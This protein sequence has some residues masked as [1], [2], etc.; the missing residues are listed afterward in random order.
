VRA[1]GIEAASGCLQRILLPATV[2]TA[3]P[4]LLGVCDLDYTFTL[5]RP[6]LLAPLP[7][8][9][10]STSAT[11]HTGNKRDAALQLLCELADQPTY[12]EFQMLLADGVNARCGP[13]VAAKTLRAAL[14]ML[15]KLE[16]QAV[17][18]F[19]SSSGTRRPNASS[20]SRHRI[21]HSH[22]SRPHR[23]LA[24]LAPVWLVWG[25]AVGDILA[26]M[27]QDASA[28]SRSSGPLASA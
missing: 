4:R 9:A 17:F 14:S 13:F 25:I 8:G 24:H 15:A 21:S 16:V 26:L 18:N 12:M 19:T 1:A 27:R 3:A 11:G 22:A 10:R 2:F 20:R 5:A 7:S 23:Q 6:R 28:K